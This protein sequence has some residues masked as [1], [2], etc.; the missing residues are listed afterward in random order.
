[1][2]YVLIGKERKDINDRILVHGLDPASFAYRVQTSEI[3][4]RYVRL[5]TRVFGTHLRAEAL[6]LYVKSREELYITLERDPLFGFRSS[7]RPELN[8]EKNASM[9]TW[10]QLMD[11]LDRWLDCLEH[12]EGLKKDPVE[13]SPSEGSFHHVRPGEHQI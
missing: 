5:P 7:F 9:T 6:A 12:E 1:M 13:L 11:L 4:T 8:N 2:E 3:M 10:G